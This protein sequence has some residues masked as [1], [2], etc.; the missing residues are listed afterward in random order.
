[1]EV[2]DD[3]ESEGAGAS[4]AG[5]DADTGNTTKPREEGDG[6]DQNSS[7][8]PDETADTGKAGAEDGNTTDA[9]AEAKSAGAGVIPNVT[10]K[11]A[12][13][14][15]AG[16]AI[17]APGDENTFKVTR[18]DFEGPGAGDMPHVTSTEE[19]GDGDIE[20]SDGRWRQG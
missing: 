14:P 2:E 13:C 1:M 15:D 17:V 11:N 4:G 18:A 20:E 19:S 12:K 10:S 8:T 9:G 3:D 16:D 6:A 5:E 7:V